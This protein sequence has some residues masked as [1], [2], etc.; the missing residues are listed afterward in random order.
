MSRF[1]HSVEHPKLKAVR[2]F[3]NIL[4]ALDLN[5]SEFSPDHPQHGPE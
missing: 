4:F 1:I 3:F 5:G 2:A